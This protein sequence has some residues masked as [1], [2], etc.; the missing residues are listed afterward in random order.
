MRN[1]ALLSD[2]VEAFLFD[3]SSKCME[4]SSCLEG[5]YSLLIFAF[6]EESELRLSRTSFG[7]AIYTT[8]MRCWLAVFVWT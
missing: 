5:A 4:C 3:Q 8:I 2:V 1:Y 6:K 7:G